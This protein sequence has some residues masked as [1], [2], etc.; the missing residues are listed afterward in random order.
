MKFLIPIVLLLLALEYVLF[1]YWAEDLPEGYN[2]D[3]STR[4]SKRPSDSA[5]DSPESGA[6]MHKTR[7]HNA[8]PGQE[9]E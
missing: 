3:D 7:D 9:S 5:S 1:P 6:E 8:G 4:S 2:R